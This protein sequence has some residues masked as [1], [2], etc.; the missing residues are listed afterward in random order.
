MKI[1]ALLS[2]PIIHTLSAIF[3]VMASGGLAPALAQ[4]TDTAAPAAGSADAAP[5]TAMH[6]SGSG[7]GAK[8]GSRMGHGMM[9]GS[10]R[11]HGMMR[12]S[13]AA[14]AMMKKGEARRAMMEAHIAYKKA[15]LK[16][17]AAQTAQWDAYAEQLR[18]RKALKMG[19]RK[20]MR[21]AKKSGTPIERMDLRMTNMT[22]KIEML[23]TLKSATENLYKALDADQKKMADVL[24]H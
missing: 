21:E 11:G 10:G 13:H 7:H 4:A 12:G 15:A 18:L 17:T 9:H 2:S 24:L 19:M 1:S 6:G 14:Q 5:A 22:A 16:I 8:R 3:I 20:T 23:K